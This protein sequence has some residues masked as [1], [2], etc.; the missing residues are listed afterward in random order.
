ML[1]NIHTM[2]MENTLDP[3][4]IG[5]TRRADEDIRVVDS[6]D[7]ETL[8]VPPPADELN[9]RLDRM[10]AFANADSSGEGFIHPVVRAIVLH[11][12]LAY[13]HPFVDGNGRTARALFY[14]S[15]LN[16]GYWLFEFL[17]ISRMILNAHGQY[18]RA[19]LNTEADE[20][21]VTYFVMFHLRVINRARTQWHKYLARQRDLNRELIPLLDAQPGLN[22]RQRALIGHAMKQTGETY[23]IESH[24][25]SHGVS[26]QTSRKDLSD[27]TARGL[28]IEHKVGRKLHYAVPEDFHRRL[29][30]KRKSPGAKHQ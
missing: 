14:W 28:L 18:G 4:K 12:W 26:R 20:A 9:D 24:R 5:R 10:V 13:D 21:D 17:P 1:F 22:H 2:I 25:R 16:R 23:T 7:G 8:H 29:G 27:L 6:R 11:F 15:M 3:E 30:V 19:F